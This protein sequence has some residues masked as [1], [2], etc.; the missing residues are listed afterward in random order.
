[1]EITQEIQEMKPNPGRL[2]RWGRN[3]EEGAG[4]LLEAIIFILA[5]IAEDDYELDS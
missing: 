3:I 5:A 4:I 1:M 2:S